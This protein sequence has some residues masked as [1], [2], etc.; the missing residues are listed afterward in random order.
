MS[1]LIWE[2]VFAEALPL[3]K[4]TGGVAGSTAAQQHERG[5]VAEQPDAGPAGCETTTHG[6]L[7]VPRQQ[8]RGGLREQPL[9]PRR[10]VSVSFPTKK[11]IYSTVLIKFSILLFE[12][13]YRLSLLATSDIQHRKKIL[14]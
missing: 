5:D 1:D 7:H 2:I 11:A 12:C 9:Q 14:C 6:A 4:L 8:R 13:Q 10:Q 3:L